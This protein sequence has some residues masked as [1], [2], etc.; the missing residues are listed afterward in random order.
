[1]G[2]AMSNHEDWVLRQRLAVLKRETD[3]M[4]EEMRADAERLNR[5]AAEAEAKWQ[6]DQKAAVE[7]RQRLDSRGPL[8]REYAFHRWRDYGENPNGEFPGPTSPAPTTPALPPTSNERPTPHLPPTSI[9][10]ANVRSEARQSKPEG[11]L[12]AIFR[13]MKGEE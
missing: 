1:M 2:A 5:E 9:T 3:A 6:A 4:R 10:R 13:Q 7:R 12:D 11:A 8:E